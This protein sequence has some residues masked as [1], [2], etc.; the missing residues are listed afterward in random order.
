MQRFM[1]V[2]KK[3][4]DTKNKVLAKFRREHDTL[5]VTLTVDS[6]TALY[7]IP[8]NFV[9]LTKE[10]KGWKLSNDMVTP[11]LPKHVC[12]TVINKRNRIDKSDKINDYFCGIELSNNETGIIQLF[13]VDSSY[14]EF[15]RLNSK[16]YAHVCPVSK[17]KVGSM[18]ATESNIYT[19]L[20]IDK[21]ISFK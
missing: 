5:I 14:Y 1:V 2:S 18:S 12:G 9:Y 21:V 4:G 15:L 10:G 16:V 11:Y 19:E 13:K 8:G 6:L 20:I 3:N 7:L 17:S